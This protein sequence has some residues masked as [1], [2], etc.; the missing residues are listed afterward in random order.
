LVQVPEHVDPAVL[1]RDYRYRASVPLAG[2]FQ[3][4]AEHVPSSLGLGRDDLIVEI[5]C[6]DGVL[7]NPLRALGYSNLLGVD[8]AENV[9]SLISRDIPTVS[10]F[11]GRD[12]AKTL[13]RDHGAAALIAANN[14]FAHVD[15]LHDF[16]DGTTT[17]L[18]PDGHYVFEVHDVSVLLEDHQFD[19]VYHEHRYY[20]SLLALEPLLASHGLRMDRVEKIATHGGSL[21]VYS[22]LRPST[23]PV[24][25]REI[26]RERRHGLGD[27]DT[28]RAFA[29]DARSAI[30]GLRALLGSVPDTS[31]V[32]G[33]GAAGRATT[34]LN[35]APEVA[36]RLTCVADESP[37][38]IGRFVPG[39]AVPIVPLEDLRSINPDVVL[40]TAWS[41]ADVLREKIDALLRGSEPEYLVPLPSPR[42]L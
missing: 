15:D 28:Y 17:L 39:V 38:R 25:R 29:A 5:G 19:T 22:S 35:V 13:E 1:F 32:V 2:H 24:V 23:S 37:E 27:L 34:L 9:T 11:F 20:Y 12:V 3:A 7:L 18:A 31:K 41:Y 26:D 30:R 6:N 14:V 8:P 10:A 36:G 42:R 40:I 16:L 33:A 21:R 4:Y